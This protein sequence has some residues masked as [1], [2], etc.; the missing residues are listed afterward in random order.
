MNKIND[1]IEKSLLQLHGKYNT[2]VI[3]LLINYKNDIT[4]D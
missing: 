1:N 3:F 2:E 4:L